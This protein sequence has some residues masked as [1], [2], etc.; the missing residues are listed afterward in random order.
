MP[1][2]LTITKEVYQFSELSDA[3]KNT[4]RDWM[5]ECQAQDND[6]LDRNLDDFETVAKILGVTF[7]TH[8][9]RLMSG[10]T[11]RAPNIYWSGF[12]SQGDGLCFDGAWDFRKEALAEIKEHAPQDEKLHAI[13]EGLWPVMFGKE[14]GLRAEITHRGNYYHENSVDIHVGH[15]DEDEDEGDVEADVLNARLQVGDQICEALRSLMRWMYR[16][17]EAD[18][19]HINS[20]ECIDETIECNEYEFEK[21][22]TV[23]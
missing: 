3:A 17:L 2:T 5:R 12:S 13:A 8:D 7:R 9:T 23:I 20:D 11:R 21:D 15:V 4:A 14:E 19:E 6:L 22:G 18:D 16:Q 1:R 10:K